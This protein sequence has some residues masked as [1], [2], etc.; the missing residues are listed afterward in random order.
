MAYKLL[1]Q[2]HH[3]VK[4]SIDSS[5]SENCTPNTDRLELTITVPSRSSMVSVNVD[6]F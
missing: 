2:S 1:F 3:N 6:K 4:L 5:K